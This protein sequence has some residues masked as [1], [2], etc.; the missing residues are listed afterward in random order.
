MSVPPGLVVVDKPAGITSHD[1]VSRCRRLFGTRKVGHAG[2]LDPM[3]T[4][5]LVIG[6]ERATKILG[7]LTTSAKGYAA[8]IRLGQTTSTEDAEGE[9]LQTVSAEHLTDSLIVEA[10]SGLRGDILQVPSAVSAIKVAGQRSYQLAREGRAVELPARPVRI[11]R[12]ELRE[13]S[14]VGTSSTWASRWTARRAPTS[15]RW[16]AT[17]ATNWGGRAPDG[18]APHPRGQLRPGSGPHAR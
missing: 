2:T 14:R 8:T 9:V 11:D 15:A 12:F 6:I 3:A 16:P 17:S 7:L 1:V 18:A 10:I 4:G 5:V 13:V